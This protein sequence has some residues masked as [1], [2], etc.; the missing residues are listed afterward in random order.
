MS[1]SYDYF[2]KDILYRMF[3][4]KDMLY[5]FMGEEDIDLESIHQECQHIPSILYKKVKYFLLNNLIIREPSG[6]H[7]AKSIKYHPTFGWEIHGDES[8]SYLGKS[9]IN[10]DVSIEIGSQSYISGRCEI[11]GNN[12]LV[13]GS[14]CSIAS[15]AQFYTSNINHPTNFMTTFNLHSNSRI[16]AE[17]KNVNLPNFNNEI[18]RLKQLNSSITIGNDVWIGRS[19]SIMPGVIISDGC[20][21]GANSLV[22]KKLEPFGVYAGTPAKLIRYRFRPEIIQRLLEIRWWHWPYKKIIANRHMFDTNLHE[23][24]LTESIK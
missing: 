20:V 11:N 6:G 13:I 1:G 24:N 8:I 10:G 3:D 9:S 19:V 7:V 18:E 4:V 2:S 14:Y 23:N 12:N 16:V 22:T 5:H 21:V 17:A 15:G